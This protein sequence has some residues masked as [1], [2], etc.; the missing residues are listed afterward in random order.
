MGEVRSVFPRSVPQAAP[1]SKPVLIFYQTYFIKKIPVHYI[2][3]GFSLM[4]EE[5]SNW[6]AQA[7]KDLDTAEYTFQGKYFEAA[8]FFSQQAVEK[9]LKALYIKKNGEL[10]KTHDLVLLAKKTGLPEELVELCK[11]I[12]PAYSY[13]RYPDVEKIPDM[14]K[15]AKEL[16]SKAKR[17]VEWLEKNL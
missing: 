12:T 15:E 6:L 10:F 3:T 16:L 9:G 7:K 17:V 2:N 14:G 11:T 13:T 5:V 1:D 8:A 4:G